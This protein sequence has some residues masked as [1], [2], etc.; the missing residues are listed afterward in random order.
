MINYLSSLRRFEQLVLIF[1]TPLLIFFIS[2][3]NAFSGLQQLS[4]VIFS[5]IIIF[6]IE[7]LSLSLKKD[8]FTKTFKKR[9]YAIK[10][11]NYR[12]LKIISPTNLILFALSSSIGGILSFYF[13]SQD[14]NYYLFGTFIFFVMFKG[15]FMLLNDLINEST[16][17]SF[18]E[19]IKL[20]LK[21]WTVTFLLFLFGLFIGYKVYSTEISNIVLSGIIFSF[22]SKMGFLI[23]VNRSK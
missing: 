13:I 17:N 19:K 22:F 14:V 20:F 3:M 15:F 11:L 21:N 8:S 16:I 12:F 23:Q 10:D 2:K 7:Y 18:K 9:R 4:L 5:L 6:G 1:G